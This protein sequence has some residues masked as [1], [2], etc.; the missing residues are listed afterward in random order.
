MEIMQQETAVLPPALYKLGS[1][2]QASLQSVPQ[3][4]EI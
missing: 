1:I 4:V 3:F 2:V